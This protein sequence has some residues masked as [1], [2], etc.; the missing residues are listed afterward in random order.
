M[1]EDTSRRCTIANTKEKGRSRRNA[2][3][4]KEEG[5]NATCDGR[6]GAYT[7]KERASHCKKSIW[8]CLLRVTKTI[9]VL[10][11]VIGQEIL[12]AIGS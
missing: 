2:Q 7:L 1:Q 6:G 5:N 11:S 10:S 12:G 3:D 4:I 8:S 9:E